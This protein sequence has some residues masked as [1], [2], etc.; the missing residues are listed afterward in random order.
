MSNGTG[1]PIQSILNA[2][3]GVN[4]LS[5]G[6]VTP[7]QQMR[8]PPLQQPSPPVVLPALSQAFDHRGSTASMDPQTSFLDSRRSSID[9]HMNNNMGHLVLGHGT[10]YESNNQST[11][12]L[13]S[14]LQQQRGIPQSR[15]NGLPP[16]VRR[17]S[18]AQSVGPRR[19][20]AI[21][22][23]NRGGGMPNP[24]S[25]E[26][27]RGFAWAF[28]D[29]ADPTEMDEDSDSANSSRQGSIAATSIHTID[30]VAHSVRQGNGMYYGCF[31]IVISKLT[32]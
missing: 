8:F 15:T 5:G 27:T 12:S 20:P 30:S 14:N 32:L 24:L 26:P 17:T 18:A 22:P 31:S 23:S 3:P 11:A 2:E 6:P 16:S 19:A 28:P 4:R 13:V 25:S 21:Q 9:S 29:Q 10:P 1:V 7:Q